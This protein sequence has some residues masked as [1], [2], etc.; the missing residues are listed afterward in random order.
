MGG[1][2]GNKEGGGGGDPMSLL[3]LILRVS[4]LHS[5]SQIGIVSKIGLVTPAMKSGL[6]EEY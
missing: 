1:G 4:I 3:T 5:T 6:E 2:E